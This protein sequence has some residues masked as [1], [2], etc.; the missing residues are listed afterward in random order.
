MKQVTTSF[1]LLL[2]LLSD[3]S[4]HLLNLVL[5]LCV[6]ASAL[7]V[8][9]SAHNN[10]MLIIGHEKL[11]QQKDAL[12]VEWRHLIIE[13]SALTEHNR[14]EKAVQERLGMKRPLRED[15]TLLRVKQ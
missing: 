3:L 4:Q 12:D 5:F 15:E 8:T 1:N 10:R 13:Q 9:I 7:A 14:I 11:I 2:I 6:I